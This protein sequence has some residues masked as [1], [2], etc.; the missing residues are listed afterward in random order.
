MTNETPQADYS[1]AKAS[2]LRQLAAGGN[3]T[4]AAELERRG[5]DVSAAVDFATMNVVALRGLV[6][7]WR[8]GGSP[9]ERAR[10]RAL[11]EQAHQELDVRATVDAKLWD[12]TGAP[13]Q[14]PQVPPWLIPTPP[15]CV[16]WQRPGGSTLYPSERDRTRAALASMVRESY[17]KLNAPGAPQKDR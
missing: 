10:N 9:E 13:P 15:R 11:A 2:V 4:A 14:R 16:N 3:R 8:D 5:L 6:R 12:G 7:A 17:Q 1:R